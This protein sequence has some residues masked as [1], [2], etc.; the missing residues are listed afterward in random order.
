[1]GE[2]S[3][4]DPP[5]PKRV[6][7]DISTCNLKSSIV[8]EGIPNHGLPGESLH[9]HHHSGQGVLLD[10]FFINRACKIYQEIIIYSHCS[11]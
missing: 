4:S 9:H 3:L 6:V 8:G 5:L 2:E 10:L 1:M 11:V 7:G